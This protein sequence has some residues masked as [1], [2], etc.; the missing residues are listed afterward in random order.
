MRQ[1]LCQAV[2]AVASK[3]SSVHSDYEQRKA[4]YE[5]REQ[6]AATAPGGGSG[7]PSGPPVDLRWRSDKSRSGAKNVLKQTLV[8]VL[9][10]ELSR[11]L[12]SAGDELE[13]R[14]KVLDTDI[15]LLE[16]K[17]VSESA[18][19]GGANKELS[20]AHWHRF[21]LLRAWSRLGIPARPPY[22]QGN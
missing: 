4:D 15:C 20:A 8:P 11:G 1:A 22:I 16:E 10:E 13:T 5:Q 21:E 12:Q 2:E 19:E 6:E 9:V 18:T 17:K 14:L 3:L 7:G